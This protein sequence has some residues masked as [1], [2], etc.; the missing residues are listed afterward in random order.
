MPP[1]A[2]R[3]AASGNRLWLSRRWCCCSCRQQATRLELLR[4]GRSQPADRRFRVPG[5]NL[6]PRHWIPSNSPP[7][8]PAQGAL[9][10]RRD[11]SPHP[12]ERIRIARRPKVRI[13][14]RAW[15][16]AGRADDHH[17]STAADGDDQA[18]STSRSHWTFENDDQR[19]RISGLSLLSADDRGADRQHSDG[20][21][22]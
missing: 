20:Q 17:R 19:R 12:T 8:L 21:P 9:K 18:G 6:P 10:P 11:Q 13:R 16:I 14:A 5:R 3:P 22:W 15:G 1:A 4:S 7:L 2:L